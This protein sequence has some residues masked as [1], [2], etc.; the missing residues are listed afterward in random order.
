M[1]TARPPLRIVQ[2]AL[3]AAAVAG[4]APHASAYCRTRTCEF[5]Q[6]ESCAQDPVTG[7]STLGVAASWSDA[8][9]TFVVQRDGSVEQGIPA[10][11]LV[12]LME[13]GFSAWSDAACSAGTGRTPWLAAVGRGRSSC[14]VVEYNCQRADN[15][16]L[17]TFRDEA[18]P[19][20]DATTIAL[21]TV[22]ANLNT[23]EILD[24]DI[25]LN[26]FHHDFAVGP[27]PRGSNATDLRVVL[28]HEIGHFLGL[29][30]SVDEDALM[31]PL[32]GDEPLPR[33]DDALGMCEV[34]GQADDDPSCLGIEPLAQDAFCLG[35]ETT[36]CPIGASVSTQAGCEPCAFSRRPKHSNN[37][38]GL[39][40][41]LAALGIVVLRRG[42][43]WRR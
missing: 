16:N 32:Y 15:V 18:T 27:P 37:G 9:A 21:T 23:G 13:A 20:L 25:E 35:A 34:L 22:I 26:S 12:D 19:G 8:C 11:T 24:A 14:D 38:Y 3:V 42:A 6:G 28:N 7:C 1:F 39:G 5:D 2:A 33:A 29:S 4:A 36:N 30:H 43:G 31:H 17:V 41:L 40:G 10:Q